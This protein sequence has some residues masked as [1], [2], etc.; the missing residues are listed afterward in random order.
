MAVD[1]LARVRAEIDGRL[2]ELRPLVAEYERLLDAV[3]ALDDEAKTAPVTAR[4]AV[5]APTTAPPRAASKPRRAAAR[6]RTASK[7]QAAAKPRQASKPRPVRIGVSEQAIVAALE[8]GSHTV[9]E[10]GVVTAIAGPQIRDGLQRLLRAGKIARTRREGRAA[11][12][13]AGSA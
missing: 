7:P 9:S 2:A 3:G 11:Y 8:H 5:T 10:L 12:E 1:L 6:L 13:L 4:G